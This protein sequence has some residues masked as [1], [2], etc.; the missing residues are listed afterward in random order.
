MIWYL[1]ELATSKDRKTFRVNVEYDHVYKIVWSPDSTAVLGFRAME[2]SIEVYRIEKRDGVLITYSK[3]NTFMKAHEND[4]IISLDISSGGR[5]IMSANNTTQIMI[6]DTKGNILDRIDTFLINN[7]AAKISP[8]G[9]YIAASGF[10]PDIKVWEVKFDNK[11][12]RVYEKTVKAFD[13]TGH[14]SGVWDFAFSQDASHLVSVC[15]DGTFRLFDIR[16]ELL[17]FK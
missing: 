15:K 12:T 2:N 4:D 16:S 14:N 11:S 6:M 1:K 5:F 3:C 17:L 7:Y 13:L 10:A 8:C 9:R